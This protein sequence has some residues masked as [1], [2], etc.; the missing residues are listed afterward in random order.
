MGETIL[1]HVGISVSNFERSKQFY[2]KALAPLG[3][4]LIM[5]YSPHAAGFGRGDKPEF[6]LGTGKASMGGSHLAFVARN[7]QEVDAFYEAA[8]AAGAT[9]NGKPGIRE[10]YHPGYYGAFVL[11]ADGHNVEAVVHEQAHG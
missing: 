9:D 8:M 6:W 1:D 4:K 3:I 2:E 11:D 5:D 10:Q 7:R